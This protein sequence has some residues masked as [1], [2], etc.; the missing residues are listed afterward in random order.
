ME[1][2]P[3]AVQTM[4]SEYDNKTILVHNE[5]P[6]ALR[7]PQ[8][9]PPSYTSNSEIFPQSLDDQKIR[10]HFIR[11]VFVILGVQLLFTFGLVCAFTFASEIKDFVWKYPAIYYSSFAVFLLTVITL[12]C[13]KSI[14]RRYPW[15]FICLAFLTL[16]LSYMVVMVASFN[17]T[18]SVMIALGSTVAVC[19][20]MIL[21]SSQT[22]LDFTCCN[23]FLLVLSIV[24]IMFGFF[25]IFFY[26]QVLHV[27]YGS[28]GALVFSLFLFVDIQLTLGNNQFGLSPEDYVF[29]AVILYLD[30][31]YIFIHLLMFVASLRQ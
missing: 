8:D 29:A 13:C 30:I 15:N 18:V 25:C 3:S 21:F 4:S 22:R 9:A 23:G 5:V 10:Q 19:F 31:I 16:S 24:V 7:A 20:G 12:A 6:A 17:D 28:L 2:P 1:S 11:K 26:S 14:Q 27:V